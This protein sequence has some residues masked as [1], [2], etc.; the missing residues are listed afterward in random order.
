M[1]ATQKND[2]LKIYRGQDYIISDH[3]VIHQATLDDICEYGEQDYYSMVYQLTATPQ[4]MK[5]QLWKM[6]VDYTTISPFELFY[7]ILYKLYPQ[8][9]TSILFGSLD[10][11]RFQVM[12]HKKK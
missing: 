12:Q 4:S 11:T 5:Y 3:I 2:E 7:S 6:G 9:K 1:I 8:E 10:L